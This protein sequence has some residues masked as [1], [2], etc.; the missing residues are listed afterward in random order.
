I[1]FQK[2][3]QGATSSAIFGELICNKLKEPIQQSVYKKTARELANEM[4]SNCESVN[5][6]RSKLEKHILKVLAE[7]ENFDMYMTYIHNPRKLFKTFIRDE[8]SNYVSEKFNVSVLPKIK[9]G[10]ILHQQKIIEAAHEASRLVKV[11]NDVDSWLKH[12]TH[13]LSDVLILS[14]KTF[15]GV[16]YNDVDINFL[17]DVMRR[18]LPAVKFDT[19][20]TFRVVNFLDKLDYRDRPDEIL[21]DH[22][23]RCCWVQCPFCKAICTKTIENHGGDHSVPFHRNIGLNGWHFSET[24]HLSVDICT[25]EVASNHSFYPNVS[26][27]IAVLWREYRKGGPKY[28]NWSITPDFSE[29]PYWK[30]VVCRFQKD[31]ENKYNKTFQGSGKIPDEWRKYTKQEAIESLNKHY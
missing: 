15:T 16:S 1:I 20:R 10:I 27:T 8:V 22:L 18:E 13:Q 28:A 3:C 2:Y 24:K 23:C 6:N 25:S 9:E 21:I 4:R 12:F 30:W 14:G 29:L 11:K 7:R 26:D 17:V 19:S 31:L 5:G